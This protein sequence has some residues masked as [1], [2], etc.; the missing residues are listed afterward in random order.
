[1][2]IAWWALHTRQLLRQLHASEA[3][4][5]LLLEESPDAIVNVD[6]SGTVQFCNQAFETMTGTPRSDIVGQ[7]LLALPAV[8]RE[9]DQARERVAAVLAGE[10]G[11]TADVQIVHRD[12]HIVKA[13]V[14]TFPLRE[15]GQI[16]GVISILR[17]RTERARAELERASLQSQLVSAQR[18]EAVGRFAGGI[19]HDFNN[20]LTIVLSSA[21]VLARAK[22]QEQRAVSDIEDAAMRGAALTRQLLTFSRRQPSEARAMDV[23][24][25]IEALR[26]M[27]E[28][29]LG[30]DVALKL[31]LAA[32]PLHVLLDPAQLDQVL[33]NLAVNARDAMPGGGTITIGTE[34]V[35]GGAASASVGIVVQDTG[36]G[37]NAATL[38]RAFEPF[39]TT[40]GEGGTGLGL[41]V[42]HGI[43]DH[44]GGT[45]RCESEPGRGTTFRIALPAVAPP[46]RAPGVG[47]ADPA[48]R[49]QR[50]VVL[51]DDDSLVRESVA[52]ALRQSGVTV[53]VMSTPVDVDAVEARLREADA[54]ISDI[55]M[56]GTTGP[57]LVD[58]LRR[59]G[60]RA[61]V[62]FVSGHAGHALVERARR[63]SRAVLIPKPFTAADVLARL[64]ELW[65]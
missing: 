5:A 3:K 33:M 53:E 54:L 62:I 31:E 59:R 42:V 19:A 32:A 50:R 51:V 11:Q 48:A 12:G 52:R 8:A 17:D 60:S 21:G 43:V 57:D 29:I 65:A 30:E 7:Q 34:R 46:E 44:A 37:M 64:D 9:V 20:I 26:P 14:K 2:L 58:A 13:E 24:E 40:K 56:P 36:S 23:N 27:L 41:S 47:R 16:V 25:G 22:P 39:F 18:M 55:V 6:R 49:G 28:R 38:A 45:V 15:E 35:G 61:P 4:H 1:V 10:G 63:D